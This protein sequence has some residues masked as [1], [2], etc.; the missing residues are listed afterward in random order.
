MP[1]G[2]EEILSRLNFMEIRSRR[3]DG[4]SIARV[5]VNPKND[6]DFPYIFLFLGLSLD[7]LFYKFMNI[8]Y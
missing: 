3:P 2:N 4:Y 5:Q 8:N 1:L 6:C 7:L